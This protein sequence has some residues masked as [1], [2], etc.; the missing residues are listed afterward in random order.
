[1]SLTLQSWEFLDKQIKWMRDHVLN[2]RAESL[3]FAQRAAD[4]LAAHGHDA[5][6]EEWRAKAD[7]M[8]AFRFHWEVEHDAA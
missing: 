1:M 5:G 6:S 4:N 2:G 7:E 8:R 3:A